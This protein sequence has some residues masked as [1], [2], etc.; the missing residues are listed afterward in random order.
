MTTQTTRFLVSGLLLLWLAAGCGPGGE[1]C[2]KCGM[3]V[4]AA[5]RWIAGLVNDSGAQERFCSPRC[6]FAHLR[7]PAGAGCRDAWIT[8]YYTQQRMPIGE[9]LF[10]SGSDVTGPMGKALVPIA[11]RAA[12]E[13]FL[14]DHRGQRILTAQEISLDALREIAGRP[15]RKEE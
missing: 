12:A 3:L 7:S 2:R 5:P 6:M 10:V 9:V 8:E 1:R 11:G 15:M 14:R 4:D 13:Q